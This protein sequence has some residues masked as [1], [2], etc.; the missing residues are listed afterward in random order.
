MRILV[1]ASAHFAITDDGALWTPTA[2]TG[3]TF[4]ARYLDV[5]DEARSSMS[6]A[7]AQTDVRRVSEWP[8]T[9]ECRGE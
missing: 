6:D 8:T 3:Y 7:R 2:S 9:C 4:W 5:F 1:T